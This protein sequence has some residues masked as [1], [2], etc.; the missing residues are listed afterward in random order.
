M[1]ARLFFAGVPAAIGVVMVVG[2]LAAAMLYA[3][4]P[5]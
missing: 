5:R 3:A 2:A 4:T 1:T